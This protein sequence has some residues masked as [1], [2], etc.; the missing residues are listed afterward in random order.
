M[1]GIIFFSNKQIKNVKHVLRLH[2]FK[3]GFHMVNLNKKLFLMITFTTIYMYF[4]FSF[5]LEKYRIFNYSDWIL[6]FL[7]SNINQV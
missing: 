3:S 4:I 5:F 1:P 7:G 2:A 6:W